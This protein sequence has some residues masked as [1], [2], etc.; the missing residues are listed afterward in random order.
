[1]RYE[2]GE[3]K[4]RC[5]SAGSQL[6]RAAI[7]LFVLNGDEGP[8]RAL[9]L[10]SE[11]RP[12][13]AGSAGRRLDPAPT[14]ATDEHRAEFSGTD[15]TNT[16]VLGDVACDN[17]GIPPGAH[18]HITQ[19]LNMGKKCTSTEPAAN[20]GTANLFLPHPTLEIPGPHSLTLPQERELHYIKELGCARK[21]S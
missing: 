14:N 18:H 3:V 12:P 20:A 19:E 16:S 4:S 1:M 7:S 2:G 8:K 17:P 5:H 21:H 15:Q 11:T 9:C 6:L 10:A 13:Q